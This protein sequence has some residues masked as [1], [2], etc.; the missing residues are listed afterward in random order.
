MRKSQSWADIDGQM[1]RAFA[2]AQSTLDFATVT[3]VGDLLLLMR[4]GFVVAAAERGEAVYEGAECA[5]DLPELSSLL[6]DGTVRVRVEW[7][8]PREK[9]HRRG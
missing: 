7:V 9:G 3:R 6:A 8:Q 1:G 5:A 2:A 4:Q